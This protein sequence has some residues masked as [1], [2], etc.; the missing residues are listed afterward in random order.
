MSKNKYHY[1]RDAITEEDVVLKHISTSDLVANPL[2]RPIA[3]GIYVGHV[4][5][6]GLC[7]I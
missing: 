4:R 6:L 1:I 2:T 7:R 3:R 5:S